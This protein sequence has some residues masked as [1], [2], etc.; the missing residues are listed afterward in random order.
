MFP[1]VIFIESPHQTTTMFILAVQVSSQVMAQAMAQGVYRCN[2]QTAHSTL[3]ET[4]SDSFLTPCLQIVD[5]LG[6]WGNYIATL[7][8]VDQLGG[9]T[10][11][12]TLVGLVVV[13]R[14]LPSLFLAPISGVVAD[15]YTRLFQLYAF[16]VIYVYVR[17]SC[18]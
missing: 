10:S 1:L 9:T 8:L 14:N 2:L 3:S 18:E 5:Q 7:R 13:V 11:S 6:Q 17:Y 4:L 16:S 15:R 12:G